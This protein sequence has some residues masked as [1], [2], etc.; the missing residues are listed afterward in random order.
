VNSSVWNCSNLEQWYCNV[1]RGVVVVIWIWM[2]ICDE[3]GDMRFT[4][5]E[6]RRSELSHDMIRLRG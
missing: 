6:K 2:W 4:G 5:V 1:W 3:L